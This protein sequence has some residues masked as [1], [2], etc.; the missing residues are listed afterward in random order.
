MG[1]PQ[2][3]FDSLE[4]VN[5]L[6]GAGVS[7]KEATVHAKTLFNIL[8]NQ[9]ITEQDM[10]KI[11]MRLKDLSA[12]I[13]IRLKDLSAEIKEVGARLSAEIKELEPRMMSR[14]ELIEHK[15]VIKLGSLMAVL[16]SLS[17]GMMAIFMKVMH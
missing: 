14:I 9:L 6:K 1:Q 11:E 15:I 17:I 2:R 10:H 13:D 8:D 5:Q 4:Y 12:E 7:E 3:I 16:F